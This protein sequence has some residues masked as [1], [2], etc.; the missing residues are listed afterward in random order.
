MGPVDVLL[1]GALSAIWGGSFIFMRYLAPLIGPVATAAARMLIAG[2]ALAAAFAVARYDAGWRRNA[3]HFLVLGVLNSAVP[4]VLYS[5]AA[6][7]LPASLEAIFNALSP[8]FGVVFAALWLG[9]RL[10]A[11]KVVGLVVG[12][13]GVAFTSGFSGVGADLPDRARD[14]R[15]PARARVLRPLGGL[16]EKAHRGGAVA[17]HRRGQPA[18]RRPR[19][20]AVPARRSSGPAP[21]DLRI[22]LV[23]VAFAL[24]CNALAYVIY[25]R[26]MATVGPT[27]A[28]T[29]TFLVPVF[30]MAW[31]WLFLGEPVTWGM[32]AGAAVILAGTWLVAG[33]PEL[34]S[35][36]RGQS[37]AAGSGEA[38]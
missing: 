14:G 6:L 26:L 27:R 23:A 25:Y 31:G 34:E 22:A 36:P 3:R 21:I 5:C 29:V 7:V 1:L 13:A 32:A 35:V 28:L 18:L 15:L 38:G 4:A 24:L 20:A 8:M 11:R 9:E 19:A 17:R 16:P 37:R 33:R 10:T 30:A 12:V 2:V